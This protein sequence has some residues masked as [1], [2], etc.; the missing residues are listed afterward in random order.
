MQLIMEAF[1]N[2]Q[3]LQ[4]SCKK[5]NILVFVDGKLAKLYSSLDIL[6]NTSNR[7]HSSVIQD[8]NTKE[9]MNLHS[10][11]TVFSIANHSGATRSLKSVE[12]YLKPSSVEVLCYYNTYIKK[13]PLQYDSH[14]GKY[15]CNV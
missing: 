2:T 8:L 5:S 6:L 4:Q 10:V 12:R 1:I 9:L 13:N 14:A 7:R 3:S 11:Q 15:V